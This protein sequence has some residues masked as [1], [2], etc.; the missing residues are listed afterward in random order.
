MS[1][2]TDSIFVVLSEYIIV[3]INMNLIHTLDRDRLLCWNNK[4]EV[5]EAPSHVRYCPR[6]STGQPIAS[7]KVSSA[8]VE[9]KSTRSHDFG[10]QISIIVKQPKFSFSTKIEF[11]F[12]IVNA[13]VR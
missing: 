5:E 6:L 9:C 3:N 1:T 2:V 7:V 10:N 4:W 12:K 11:Q 8:T 13:S